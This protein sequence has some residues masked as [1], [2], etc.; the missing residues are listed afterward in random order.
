MNFSEA[1][2]II[3]IILVLIVIVPI[4]MKTIIDSSWANLSQKKT[5]FYLG[6]A[7]L[8]LTPLMQKTISLQPP[9]RSRIA[10]S[11]RIWYT[12]HVSHSTL[13]KCL[14]LIGT[15]EPSL[16]T[17]LSSIIQPGKIFIDI[18][19]N[20]G[21]FT[22]LAAAHGMRVHAIEPS[23]KNV[24]ILQQNIQLNRLGNRITIH[25]IAAS[26]SQGQTVLLE[27]RINGM[28]NSL[29]ST[30]SNSLPLLIQRSTVPMKRLDHIIRPEDVPEIGIIKIDVEGHESAVIKGMESWLDQNIIWIIEIDSSTS[31]GK[32]ILKLFRYKNYT[33][34]SLPVDSIALSPNDTSTSERVIDI[35]TESNFRNYVFVKNST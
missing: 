1:L 26:D 18:G 16:V 3:G 28:W 12:G 30:H 2:I 10:Q 20:E 8:R 35:T 33:I 15:Y 22:I 4:I 11:Q 6:C 32:E 7:A 13:I 19:A 5:A 31:S 23:R 25:P 14:Y 9:A 29:S 21:F 17:Y 27:N 24:A 34:Y